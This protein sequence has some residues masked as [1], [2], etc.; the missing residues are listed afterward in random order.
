MSVEV[1]FVISAVIGIASKAFSK[2]CSNM[3]PNNSVSGFSMVLIINSIV[4]CLFFFITGGFA[5][6]VNPVIIWYSV[7]YAVVA[8]IS[9]IANIIVY[10]YTSVSNVTVISNSCGMVATVMIGGLIFSENIGSRT[11]IRLAV[12]ILAM[13]FVF[14]DQRKGARAG[15]DDKR[16]NKWIPLV[17]TVAVITLAGCANTLVLKFFALSDSASEETSFFFFTRCSIRYEPSCSI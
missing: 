12:M 13:V 8:A 11:V 1:L 6:S 5:F 3:I 14:L 17:L 7:I 4:A 16:K 2:C 15:R 9:I 10:R